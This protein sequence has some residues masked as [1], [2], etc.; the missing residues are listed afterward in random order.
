VVVAS[1]VTDAE[2]PVTS[3]LRIVAFHKL[4]KL[5]ALIDAPTFFLRQMEKRL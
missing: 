1:E 5:F 2:L 4:P 3:I